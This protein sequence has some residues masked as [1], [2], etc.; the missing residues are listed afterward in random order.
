MPID[1]SILAG[2][3]PA[4]PAFSPLK[5]L[6]Q[7]DAYADAQQTRRD[8]QAERQRQQMIDT[9]V[10]QF[11]EDPDAA[12]AFLRTRD[13]RAAA[14]LEKMVTE[15]RDATAKA[16]ETELKNELAEAKML[17]DAFGGDTSEGAWRRAGYMLRG[18]SPHLDQILG[19]P[20]SPDLAAQVANFGRTEAQRMEALAKALETKRFE[21]WAEA[22][23]TDPEGV[24]A[25]K[26]AAFLIGP[27]KLAELERD[28]LDRE[29]T[30]RGQDITAETT[31][32]GQDLTAATARRGQDITA[33][34]AANRLAFDQTEA[35]K[36]PTTAAGKAGPNVTAIMDQIETLSGRINTAGGGPMSAITGL[37]RR[38]LARGQ[39]DNDVSEY[40]ALVEGMI[41]MVARAV[42]H[43]GAL[44]QQDVDSVR[45]LFPL[46]ED[47][48]TLAQNKIQRVRTLLEGAAGGSSGAPKEGDTRPITAPGYP[49]GAQATFQGGRWVRTQ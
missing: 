6:A 23:R 26:A 34:T 36:P 2:A 10:Q 45:A 9:V 12:I 48:Q 16:R 39:M 40:K 32:R 13:W 19:Q 30:K 15:Q 37:V 44:T 29:T 20:Y 38:G 35:A 46:V 33:A 24:E 14:S 43:I 8:A 17:A 49:P 7:A 4:A 5:T 3:T 42:G 28:T 21:D 18:K 11:P 25:R 27:T 41:P 31:R 47:N 1:H 22:I